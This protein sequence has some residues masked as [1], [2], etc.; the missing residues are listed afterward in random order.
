MSIRKTFGRGLATGARCVL[1]AFFSI[2]LAT[3]THQSAADTLPLQKAKPVVGTPS[4]KQ[5]RGEEEATRLDRAMNAL[6]ESEAAQYRALF[7]AQKKGEWLRADALMSQIGDKRLMGHVLADRF[8]R[9]GA[10]PAELD[11]WL[12]AYATLPEAE[13]I[14]QKAKK[15]GVKNPTPPA[16]PEAW[17]GI[18]ENKGAVT[19]SP[20][21]TT[22]EKGRELQNKQARAVQ[23]A[24]RKGYPGDALKILT[25]AKKDLRLS[26]DFIHDLEAVIGA[27]FF[28]IGERLQAG[29][30][31][32]TAAAAGEPL[33]LWISGLLA[34]EQRRFQ[35]A[36]KNFADLS[37][38]TSLNADSRA[39]ASFWA[40]RAA[41]RA[42][43]SSARH[44]LEQA[45]QAPHSFY[46]L[47]ASDLLGRNPTRS[48]AKTKNAPVWDDQARQVLKDNQA[49]WR[50]LA[51]VQVGEPT[52]AEA[53]LSR[54]NP[55]GDPDKQRAM[56]ALASYVPMPALAV[57]VASL[58]QED[59]LHPSFY[60]VLPWQPEGGFHIDRALLF[61]LA[62]QESFFDPKAR[63]PRGAQGLMQ[64]MPAT[65]SGIMKNEPEGLALLRQDKLLD[66]AF[67]MALGQKYVRHLTSLPPI[68]DNLLMLLAAYNGGP[69]KAAAWR[70]AQASDDSLLFLESIPV[71][72]TRTYIARV[73]P[74]YWAY[75]ARLGKAS[76]SLQQMAAGLWPRLSLREEGPLRVA[77]NE[78]TR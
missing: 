70:E 5:L 38:K 56:L 36:Q 28:S 17:R 48:F 54:L 31:A 52:R 76:P 69:A 59:V 25:E 66:P 22:K 4:E 3:N 41:S 77:G 71:Q 73:L 8:E 35:E 14:Y 78:V 1:V 32:K 46:G 62:R 13:T 18:G 39:A 33:G 23:Q 53:E 12:K 10:Q 20:S 63:S 30:L 61:A 42:G 74:H 6:S 37:A 21:L 58:A 55:Q 2:G 75:R 7:A 24:L 15:A 26:Q 44:F 68:G 60:P 19:F 9:R 65:A 43:D 64:I 47:M 50:A 57:R 67:N 51:L 34:W 45:A 16:A 40:Y 11:S 27:A 72:E 49:G 29:Q